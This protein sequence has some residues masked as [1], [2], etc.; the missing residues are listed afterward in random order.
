M[1]IIVPTAKM[2]PTFED[3]KKENAQL[4]GVS[5]NLSLALKESAKIIEEKEKEKKQQ[6]EE[7]ER[8]QEQIRKLL[9]EQEGN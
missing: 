2:M 4:R 1:L 8:L 7:I 9:E 5:L 3:M 6:E